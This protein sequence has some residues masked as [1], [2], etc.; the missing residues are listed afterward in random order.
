M[1][2]L[3]GL[4]AAA[5]PPVVKASWPAPATQWRAFVRGSWSAPRP[6]SR[7]DILRGAVR[8]LPADRPLVVRLSGP[9][10]L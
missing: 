4:L 2:I 6:P 3:A 10:G 7:L 5:Q 1:M 8:G 9:D